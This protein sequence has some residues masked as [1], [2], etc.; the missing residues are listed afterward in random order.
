MLLLENQAGFRSKYSTNHHMFTLK[1]I[2]DLYL[3]SGRILF[4]AFVDYRKAF[5]TV[6]RTAYRTAGKY[7]F[8]ITSLVKYSRQ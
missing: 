5:D 1:R 8:L 6:N 4:C 7:Y 2:I 3:S